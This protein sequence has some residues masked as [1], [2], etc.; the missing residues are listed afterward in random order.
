MNI[1][2]SWWFWFKAS[3][4]VVVLSCIL[5]LTLKLPAE[6]I[7]YIANKL[8]ATMPVAGGTLLI[9]LLIIGVPVYTFC[10][11]RLVSILWRPTDL[12][13]RLQLSAYCGQT[14]AQHTNTTAPPPEVQSSSTEPDR[15]V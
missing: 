15:P 11:T 13:D 2:Q 12:Y 14:S 5:G 1:L 3:W 8:G 10:F 6:F 4:R 7:M 9:M